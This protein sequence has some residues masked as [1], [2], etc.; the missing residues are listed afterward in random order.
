MFK[1]TSPSTSLRRLAISL[2]S[3]VAGFFAV[4]IIAQ[5]QTRAIDRLAAEI[6][7]NAGPSID[8]LTAVRGALHRLDLD[9]R[10]A[11]NVQGKERAVELRATS[12]AESELHDQLA[13]YL[14]LPAFPGERAH[15]Q[16]AAGAL[17]RFEAAVERTLSRVRAGDLAG[18]RSFRD[19]EM[20]P[21]VERADTAIEVLVR[22]NSEQAVQI[23]RRIQHARQRGTLLS[24]LLHGLTALVAILTVGMV[25]R[26]LRAQAR[27]D[28]ERN[29]LIEERAS[30]L[31]LFAARVAHDIK[32]P[33]S[34][35]ALRAAAA[36]GRDQAWLQSALVRVGHGVERI[37]QIVEGLLDFAR[38]GAR[39]EAGARAD[40][41]ALSAELAA[42]LREAATAAGTE[43]SVEHD[44]AVEAAMPR[45]AAAVVLGNLLQN[46]LKF[47]VE[48]P[49]PRIR[50]IELSA[51]TRSDG[52]R[53]EIRDTGPGIPPELEHAIFEPYAR[54]PGT[55]Q[56]G[57]GLGLATVK[58]LVESYGG[59]V[60]VRSE[61]G[62]GSC[63]WLE[64]PKPPVGA[65]AIGG[66]ATLH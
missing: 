54:A 23:G 40:L 63:F 15:Y 49:P 22:Y 41:A 8:R 20:V 47:I 10:E 55:R 1:R 61:P 57:L 37:N 7:E 56:P 32:N 3:V 36:P 59:S 60:G 38:S 46:A 28:E 13:A 24:Y 62:R 29:L 43:I 21:A 2:L 45:W 25:L 16:D 17:D 27:L 44:E 26:G 31:E 33:L 5:R 64:L 42:E 35:I 48:A 11:I 18:A 4:T 9:A 52:V 50:R 12:E 51:R 58:R 53:V 6:S 39:P 30:E 19:K 14:E 34:T 66:D 65:Q